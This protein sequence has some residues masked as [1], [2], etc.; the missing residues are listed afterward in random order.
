MHGL[1][2]ADSLQDAQA[3]ERHTQQYFEIYGYSAM[4]KDGWWLSMVMPRIP[5]DA[6]PN[7]MKRFAPSVGDAVEYLSAV[8]CFIKDRAPWRG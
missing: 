1:T 5:W 4:Y 2:F 6:T 7:T 3:P 8:F